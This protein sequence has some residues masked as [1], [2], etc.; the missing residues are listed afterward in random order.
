MQK[1]IIESLKIPI[2]E[3][4]QGLSAEWMEPENAWAQVLFT[5]GAGAGMHHKYMVDMAYLLAERGLASLRYNFMYMELGKGR[6][7]VQKKTVS[8]I[9]QAIDFQLTQSYLPLFIGGKSYGG[10]MCSWAV[11][12]NPGTK[13]KGLIYW[14]FPLHAPGRD[15]ADRA[16]HFLQIKIPMLFLQGSKDKLAN[17]DLLKPLLDSS[18]DELLVIEDADHSFKVPKRTGKTNEEV[19]TELADKVE[20]WCREVLGS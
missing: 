6:P 2:E 19:L 13:V 8:S 3:L 7:D 18:K 10:R 16:G 4:P 20:N 5:H 9:L 11:A 15:S 12:E 17:L 14:G 1:V